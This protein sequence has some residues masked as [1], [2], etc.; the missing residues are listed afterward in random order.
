MIWVAMG[1]PNE[2]VETKT[3]AKGAEQPETKTRARGEDPPSPV[4]SRTW[5]FDADPMWGVPAS[6]TIGETNP[7]NFPA[8]WKV[9]ADK[10]APSG[11]RVFGVTKCENPK[12]AVFEVAL[13]H[14]TDYL[15]F[16]AEVWIKAVD[17]QHDQGGG[18][19]WRAQDYDNYYV[20]RWNPIEGNLRFYV[21][22]DS[23]RRKLAEVALD[24]EAGKWQRMTLSVAGSHFEVSM[25]DSEP[26]N[27][28]DTTFAKP[29]KLGFWTKTDAKT[30]FDELVVSEPGPG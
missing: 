8:T 14:D 23:A 4:P 1:C 13:I 3:A 9:V 24:L 17:G 29:G 26:L 6:I 30:L 20:A 12:A 27:V 2:A 15:D 21:I 7:H 19:V 18:L 5:N 16:E 11:D 22:R 28:D 25:N 10:N